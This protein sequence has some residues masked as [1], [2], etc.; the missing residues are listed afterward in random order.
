MPLRLH[1]SLLG[2]SPLPAPSVGGQGT[3]F[4]IAPGELVYADGGQEQ[5]GELKVFR[6]EKKQ[7]LC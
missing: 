2:I 6:R 7:V 1:L 3:P 5:E 4:L